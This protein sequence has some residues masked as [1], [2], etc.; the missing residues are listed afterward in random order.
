MVLNVESKN[1]CK[2]PKNVRELFCGQIT[3]C[4]FG[5]CCKVGAEA[6]IDTQDYRIVSR[7]F[8]RI[9]Y[10]TLGDDQR[11]ERFENIRFLPIANSL[12]RNLIGYMVAK[13]AVKV[14]GK[15][16]FDGMICLEYI[17]F[18]QNLI[19][20]I[21]KDAFQGL[22]KLSSINLGKKILIK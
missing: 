11:N 4:K 20:T 12:L 9:Q 7:D 6:K 5:L 13:T 16:H 18:Q 14:I 3:R 17:I 2:R 19:E 1:S 15:E 21:R 22:S 8:S 10:L